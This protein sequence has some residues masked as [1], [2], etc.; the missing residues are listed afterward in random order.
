MKIK[1]LFLM[2]LMMLWTAN[3]QAATFY[4]DSEKGVDTAI[5]TS[6]TVAVKTMVPVETVLATAKIGD[7][8]VIKGTPI[9]GI[10]TDTGLKDEKGNPK[11]TLIKGPVPK[12]VCD[13]WPAIAKLA[14][15][16]V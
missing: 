7:S 14:S 6:D 1:T 8:L 10:E 11:G 3:L 2:V 15:I 4:I 13:R 16:I 5:G 12:E 9:W